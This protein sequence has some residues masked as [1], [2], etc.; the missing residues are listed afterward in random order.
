MPSK[1]MEK[2]FLLLVGFAAGL[3]PIVVLYIK[4]QISN[5]REKSSNLVNFTGKLT[6]IYHSGN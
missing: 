4:W 3:Q 1:S 5:V 2:N 6:A